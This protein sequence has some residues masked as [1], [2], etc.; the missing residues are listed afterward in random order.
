MNYL[1]HYCNL[2]RK[3]EKRTPPEGYTE[4]HH[5]F[6]KSIFGKN[7]KIVIL[8]GREHYIAHALLERI[9][10][11]RYGSNDIKT[12]KMIIAFWCMNNQNTKNKYYN[13]YL[14]ESTKIKY[15]NTIKGKKLSEERIEK[16][17]EINKGKSWWTDGTST[18][19]CKDCPND[20]WYK[21]RPNINVGRFVSEE[22]KEKI[23]N[24]NKNMQ[25]TDEHKEKI[26]KNCKDRFWWNDGINDKH[27]A[28][29]PGEGWILGRLYKR[30][31]SEEEKENIRKRTSNRIVSEETRKKQSEIRKGR[32]WWTNGIDNKQS[33]CCPG[34][35]WVSG[36]TPK[37]L[38]Q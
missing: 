32:K 34:N 18:K 23:R 1:K 24:K 2:I 12:N 17:R 14:Y 3:A 25:F 11:K 15:I 31:L 30:N 38:A 35:D 37:K 29:C 5:I 8:T 36:R 19:H 22:T 13:S 20:G 9:Y 16:L 27:C 4:K 7:N 33:L 10:V 26:R 6:P 28:N 21:G